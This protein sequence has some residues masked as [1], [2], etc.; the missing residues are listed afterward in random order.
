MKKLCMLC[1]FLIH[2]FSFIKIKKAK[3]DE[4]DGICYLNSRNGHIFI[5]K[6]LDLSYLAIFTWIIV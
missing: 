5:S 6:K 3:Q 2:L 4:F 1:F